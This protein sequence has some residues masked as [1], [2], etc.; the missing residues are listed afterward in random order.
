MI[1]RHARLIRIGFDVPRVG[2]DVLKVN[3][4]VQKVG[5]EALKVNVEVPRVGFEVPR[6]IFTN[7]TYQANVTWIFAPQHGDRKRQYSIRI[8]DPLKL[9]IIIR[10]IYGEYKT[11]IAGRNT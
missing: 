3:V 1:C 9:P 4:E 7:T 6:R 10:R 5:I 2:F 8:N 11:D